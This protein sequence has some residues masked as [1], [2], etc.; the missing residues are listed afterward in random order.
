MSVAACMRWVDHRPDV[1]PLTGDIAT[2][3]RRSGPSDADLAALETAL[4]LADSWN[5]E[6]VVVTA[7]PPEA[8][9]MLRDALAA[10]AARAVRVDVTTSAPSEVL[11]EEID[12]ALDASVDTIVCGAWSLDRGSGAVPAFLAAR[13]A[14]AQ[15]LG[16]ITVSAVGA[17]RIEAIR[18]LDGGRRE[19]LAAEVPMVLSVEAAAARPRR[20]SMEGV[21]QAKTAAI[22]ICAVRA[23]LIHPPAATGPYR[24]RARFL[25]AP[26]GE[27]DARSRILALSGAT[28]N[29]TPPQRLELEPEEAAERILAQLREWGELEG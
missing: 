9:A 15:A 28:S 6:V 7:G 3:P 18:R 13:R 27:Q 17:G 25:A 29:R 16:L 4:R 14:A 5:T 2:D 22:E 8:E 20:A 19:R 1:D 10:G 24:P 26:G 11:A 21:L 12:R 23:A